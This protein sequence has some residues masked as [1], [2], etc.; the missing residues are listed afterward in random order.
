M[1]AMLRR[2]DLAAEIKSRLTIREVC[3]RY[4]IRFNSRGKTQ[5]PFHDDKHPSADIKYG[6]FNCWVCG[7]H[8]DIFDFVK[9]LFDIEFKQALI[10]LDSDFCLGLTG[11]EPDRAAYDRWVREKRK[12]ESELELYRDEYM[13]NVRLHRY[14][15]QAIKISIPARNDR[16]ALRRAR[17]TATM[18][19]LNE[20]FQTHP[21]K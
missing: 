19:Y 15:W 3:E 8:L 5:C 18:E 13:Q 14:I 11:R 2:P 20:Y 12:K 10:R 16:Q 4:G 6:Q 7:L 1:A 21:W 9:R 17:W